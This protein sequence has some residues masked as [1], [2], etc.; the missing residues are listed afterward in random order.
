[1]LKSLLQS[2]DKHSY[3]MDLKSHYRRQVLVEEKLAFL[4]LIQFFPLNQTLLVDRQPQPQQKFQQLKH[5]Q[6]RIDIF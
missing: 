2:S 6:S 1:M 4:L 3:R 5:S